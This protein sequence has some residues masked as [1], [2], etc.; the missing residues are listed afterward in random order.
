MKKKACNN[1]HT[2]YDLQQLEYVVI[3]TCI[4]TCIH[5]CQAKDF[6]HA[7]IK[8]VFCPFLARENNFLFF[9]EHELTVQPIRPLI[10][11]IHRIP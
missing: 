4:V 2:S 11:C 3:V 10:P 8:I 9:K 1:K 7:G 5:Y 6:L